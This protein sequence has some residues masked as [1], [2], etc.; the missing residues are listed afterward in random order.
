MA[1]LVICILAFLVVIVGLL[2]LLIRYVGE[3]AELVRFLV[4]G[5]ESK[6]RG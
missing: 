6:R 2:V 3:L 5:S 1:G 4:S